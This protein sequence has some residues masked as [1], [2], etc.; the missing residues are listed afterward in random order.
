MEKI[1]LSDYDD[2]H[3]NFEG[4]IN[5]TKR[6][7]IR[8]P[9]PTVNVYSYAG[10]KS[11]LCRV[12]GLSG[13]DMDRIVHYAAWIVTD[14]KETGLTKGTILSEKELAAAKEKYGEG[15]FSFTTGAPAIEELVKQLDLENIYTES[16]KKEI[17]IM[18]ALENL[19][20]KEAEEDEPVITDD[21]PDIAEEGEN[22]REKTEAERFQEELGELRA[23]I[24]AICYITGSPESLFV[25]EVRM[26][27]L[28]LRPAVQHCANKMPYAVFHD[29]E[30]LYASV[31][32]RSN[33]IRI[34]KKINTPEI[35]LRNE[36]R[37]LQE[38]VDALVANGERGKAKTK[39]NGTP[40]YCLTD[41]LLH[42]TKLF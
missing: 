23:M 18:A 38:A 17:S 41:I 30:S 2:V 36:M 6:G 29:L 11:P 15:S 37:L 32:G 25:R 12:T 5:G 27:P 4:F 33:R 3:E 40:L 8:L 16:R 14:P 31:A 39:G 19:Y 9:V 10:D 28:E 21:E 35:I 26:F 20:K 22:S 13:K 42:S 24:D 34:F 7:V 1:I